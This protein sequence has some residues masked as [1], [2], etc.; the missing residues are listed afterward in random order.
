M[1]RLAALLAVIP[2]IAGAVTLEMPEGAD[3]TLSE[4]SDYDNYQLPVSPYEDGAITTLWTEGAVTRQAWR[5]NAPGKTP[6]QHLAFLRKQLDAAGYETIFECSD[7]DCGGFDF[8]FGIEVLSAPAMYV[9]LGDFQFLAAQRQGDTK[10]EYVSLLVSTTSAAGFVQ[11]ISVGPE[12]ITVQDI[13]ASS[14]TLPNAGASL[15]DALVETGHYVLDDL[16]FETGSSQLDK[17]PFPSLA[18]LAL[19]LKADPERHI[20]LVG[21]TDAQ[22]QLS[23]NIALSRRRASAVA[24]RLI[25]LHGANPAQIDSEGVGYLAPRASNLH[26]EG[27]YK[28]RRVEV[29]LTTTR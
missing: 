13:A 21:H 16:A 27:R 25:S 5:V 18:E 12:D 26:D 9:D 23:K 29:I 8:R 14:K 20:V 10:P 17:G 7:T 4:K 2:A 28:N 3:L 19:F 11:I 6:L 1:I 24:E 22:G 15:G